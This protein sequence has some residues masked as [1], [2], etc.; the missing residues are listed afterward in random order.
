MTIAAAV[1]WIGTCAAVPAAAAR[2]GLR[3]VDSNLRVEF[4]SFLPAAVIGTM[5]GACLH[6]VAVPNG[7][8]PVMA[9]PM[10]VALV[11]LIAVAG[12]VDLRTAWAP[13]ELM[14]PVCLAAGAVSP[15]L[16]EA[17]ELPA[18][19]PGLA[20]FAAAHT[21]WEIQLRVGRQ[22]LPPADFIV[23]ALPAVLFGASALAAACYGSVA[24]LLAFAGLPG[25]RSG[26]RG[27]PEA[28]AGAAHDLHAGSG[29]PVAL[30]GL[31][32][33]PLLG[34]LAL[35]AVLQGFGVEV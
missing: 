5:I 9:H 15:P 19:L 32:S 33:A 16:A 11:S 17:T 6:F 34:A 22:W 12:H 4:R 7:T 10:S 35:Q 23:L 29:T 24:A 30:V 2:H 1:L 28:L 8:G 31:A 3:R 13:S 26:F 20:L 25:G 27:N 14:L 21:A 18:P